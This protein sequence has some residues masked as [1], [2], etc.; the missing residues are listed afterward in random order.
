MEAR[1]H[2]SLVHVDGAARQAICEEA[3]EEQREVADF[4]EAVALTAATLLQCTRESDAK[5]LVGGGR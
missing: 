2:R 4:A 5:R 1:A 3:G